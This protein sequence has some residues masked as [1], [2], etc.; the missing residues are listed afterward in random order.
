VD[1]EESL[2]KQC[3][4]VGAGEFCGSFLP[5]HDDYVIAADNGYT[6][7]VARGITPNLV[8]GDF[9][10]LGSAP[11][12]SN[13]IYSP[14]E[15]DDT[16][17]MLAVKQG[18]A[19]GCGR[20]IIDG[21]LG[22]RLD[23]TLANIQILA[24]IAQKGARGVLLGRDMCVTAVT[25]GSIA[26]KPRLS[27]IISVFCAGG[28]AEGVTLTGLK[29]PLDDAVLTNEY[30]LGISNEFTGTPATVAVSKGTLIVMWQGGIRN[31]GRIEEIDG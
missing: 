29:Y 14:A 5:E 22:G 20:F 18:L 26:F 23:H 19:R 16:D 12:H 13:I 28:K 3:F 27:G 25:D 30:P 8:V 4:I 11:E 9:D 6:E 21:G 31:Y 1:I 2:S 15:K 24:Y 10:S 17:M 7:L